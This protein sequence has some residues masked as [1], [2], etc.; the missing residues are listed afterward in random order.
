MRKK[1][2]L[3]IKHIKDVSGLASLVFLSFS[4][5]PSTLYNRTVVLHDSKTEKIIFRQELFGRC[6]HVKNVTLKMPR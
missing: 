5:K 1:N 3:I 2:A 4:F 6:V